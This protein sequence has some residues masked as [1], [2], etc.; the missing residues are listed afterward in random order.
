MCYTYNVKKLKTKWFAK[1]AKKNGIADLKLVETISNLE[2]EL[3]STN[4]GAN[5]FK[6]RV[7]RK[8]SGKSGGF[9]TILIFKEN[10]KAVFVY[11]FAKNEE[12]N[13]SS[14]ELEYFKTLGKDLLR[15]NKQ[16]LDA[17]IKSK[18]LLEIEV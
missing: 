16:Q 18:A 2:S 10:D 14:K 1:W 3:S 7:S 12:D 4:L 8:S 6:V 9:R 11:G 13:I 17:A 15:L 5:V